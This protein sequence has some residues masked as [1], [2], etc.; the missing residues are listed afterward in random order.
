MSVATGATGRT[1]LLPAAVYSP[2]F[3]W[4][5][6][7]VSILYAAVFVATDLNLFY[8]GGLFSA[9]VAVGRPWEIYF[10]NF[11]ARL[12]AYSLGV[13]PAAQFGR[14][15]GSGAGAVH[16]YAILYICWPTL[17]VVATRLL[18]NTTDKHVSAFCNVATL[19][20]P[21]YAYGF[22]TEVWI[23]FALFWPTLCCCI[24]AQSS[25]VRLAALFVLLPLL[26]F[27]HE[28]AILFFPI[29]AGVAICFCRGRQRLLILATIVA[30]L[31]LWAAVRGLVPACSPRQLSPLQMLAGRP[32]VNLVSVGIAVAMAAWL[33]A[34]VVAETAKLG[35]ERANDLP[36]MAGA[37]VLALYVYLT[38]DSIYGLERYP[39]RT[40]V[41]AQT[42]ALGCIC[43]GQLLIERH[44]PGTSW[45]ME[46]AT[47]LLE[48]YSMNIKRAVVAF[49]GFSI[50][51][52]GYAT[53]TFVAAWMDFN[54][55]IARI[56][57]DGAPA[58]KGFATLS[59]EHGKVAGTQ[60]QPRS[61]RLATASTPVHV[62]MRA[63]GFETKR[64]VIIDASAEGPT[65]FNCE[66]G[67]AL[68]RAPGAIG[69]TSAA[70]IRQLLCDVR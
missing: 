51:A 35:R 67:K 31:A 11:P 44:S 16:L 30:V 54:K 13:I 29:L 15:T 36:L 43:V 59:L 45:A 62:I 26:L 3:F 10:C 18:D 1:R 23:S 17:G 42:F 68:E 55:E 52:H 60:A 49:L 41:L 66:H 70:L 19:T 21:Y 46:F 69:P 63:P 64:L 7:A 27:T 48:R 53:A 8:D 33:V 5:T 38:A 58:P 22:P 28:A 25:I 24:C 61:W 65:W 34:L 32:F 37:I 2:V 39:A 20:T 12:G 47:K 40:L 6:L 50:V 14:L 9:V 4:F 56:A 57:F